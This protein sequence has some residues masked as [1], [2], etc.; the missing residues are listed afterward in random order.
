LSEEGTHMSNDLDNDI[1]RTVTTIVG[2]APDIGTPPSRFHQQASPPPANRIRFAAAAALVVGVGI[3]ALTTLNRAATD[4]ATTAPVIAGPVLLDPAAAEINGR[5]VTDGST[6]EPSGAVMSPDGTIYGLS[7]APTQPIETFPT[8]YEERTIG[9][10][11]AWAFEDGSAP[12]QIRRGVETG[13]ATLS[14]TTGQGDMWPADLETLTR[15]L[16]IDD[17]GIVTIDLPTG[18][19]SLSAGGTAD[20][21]LSTL[22]IRFEGTDY[23]LN[24]RQ[25]I[26]QPVGVFLSSPETNPVPVAD[27]VDNVWFIEGG[28]T[29]GW[30][31][32]VGVQNDT[33][34]EI[35]GLAPLKVLIAT[36]ESLQPVAVVDW[37]GRSA[38]DGENTAMTTEPSESTTCSV[39]ALNLNP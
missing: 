17:A 23:R 35:S 22:T 36:A 5:S 39:Q 18:W 32:I 15:S 27:E 1:K 16:R 19:R 34:Y 6:L 7:I 37:L 28:T 13:C 30:N 31:T 10:L 26:G 14:V 8:S 4:T 11:D 2:T 33:L 3:A 12:T 21:Y 38:S 29:P 25:T 24:S 9:G 20:Q